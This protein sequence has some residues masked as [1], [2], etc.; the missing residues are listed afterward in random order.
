[1][2]SHVQDLVERYIGRGH[3]SGENNISL[4]CPFHKG[5]QES[6]P[7]FSVNVDSGAFQCFTCKVSG[8]LPKLLKLLQLPDSVVDAELRDIRKE[9]EENRERRKWKKKA[10]WISRDPFLASMILPE[11]LL[12][13]YKLLP[14]KLQAEGFDTR[15][16]EYMEIGYD[17]VNNRITYPIRDIYGNLAGLAGG[18]SIAGQYPKYKVYQGGR[19][20]PQTN[21]WIPSEYGEW[22]DE[23][24]PGYLF[25]NHDF[26]WNFDQVYPT[27]FF[28]KSEDQY[29]ILVEGYKACLWV[30]QSGF[31]NVVALMGSSLSEKQC[32]LL[33]RISARIILFLDQDQAGRKGTIQIGKTLRKLGK[34]GILVAHYPYV[35]DCQ[36]DD[37]PGYEVT[38]SITG[39]IP[40]PQWLKEIRS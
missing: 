13:P 39:A 38:A 23:S 18:A 4:R 25:H 2:R 40:Y 8:G 21:H 36:P 7:S 20:D 5:G 35:D 28:T 22:F 17:R 16:L 19:K 15:W 29:I 14:L 24:Y 9:L 30:L 34:S 3:Y 12:R 11:S 33:N 31:S 26:L 1:M 32:S 10:E 27:L 6:R 37:L